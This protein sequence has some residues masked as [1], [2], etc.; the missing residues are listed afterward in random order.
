MFAAVSLGSAIALIPAGMLVDRLGARWVLVIGG[1]VN[2]LGTLAAAALDK[3]VRLPGALLVAGIGGSAVPVA[4][5]SSLM[6]AFAPERRGVVDGLAPAR[7]AARRHDRRG[8]A[9]TARRRRRGAARARRLRHR[10]DRHV[11]RVRAARRPSPRGGRRLEPHRPARRA[12]RPRHP[13]RARRRVRL[14][15]R[16][17]RGAHLLHPRRPRRRLHPHA[18]GDR[19]R[20]RERRRRHLTAAVGAARPI[21]AGAHGERAR[22]ARPASRR[23]RRRDHPARAARRVVPGL[24]ATAVLAFGVFGFNGI[25]YLLVGELAGLRPIGRR[26]GGR[27]DRDLRRGRVHRARRRARGRAPR[28][29]RALGDRGGR[30]RASGA[31]IAWRWLPG[32]GP[33]PADVPLAKAEAGSYP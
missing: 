15:H 1:I 10:R 4:G 12:A 13:A 32:P 20:A 7:R 31:T 6:R 22:C 25:V 5:M 23:R 28:L 11:G 18:G 14:H 30:R 33:P 3:P 27:L 21:A 24:A 26:G 2:G 19:V 29:R 8:G 16:P 17:D 9:A